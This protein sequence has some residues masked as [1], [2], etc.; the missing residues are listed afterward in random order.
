MFM[1]RALSFYFFSGDNN[2]PSIRKGSVIIT[3]AIHN[4]YFAR[5]QLLVRYANYHL[6]RIWVLAGESKKGRDDFFKFT[7][8]NKNLRFSK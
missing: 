3:G 1:L 4:V 7:F 2:I 6:G 8:S 5:Q